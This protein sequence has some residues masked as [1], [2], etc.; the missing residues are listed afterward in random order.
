M[1]LTVLNVLTDSMEQN[2]C[3]EANGSLGSQEISRTLWNAMVHYVIHNRLPRVRIL[4]QINPIHTSASKFLKIHFNIILKSTPRSSKW[5]FTLEFPRPNP[6]CT[7]PAPLPI[8]PHTPPIS[9]FLILQMF[10][11]QYRSLTL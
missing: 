1:T 3:R 9:V 4:S 8:L 5:S 2:P 10:D 6:V 11:E 7:S